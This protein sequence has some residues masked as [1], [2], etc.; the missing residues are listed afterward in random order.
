MS[1]ENLKKQPKF[2]ISKYKN[3]YELNCHKSF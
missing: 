1:N 2:L 3:V